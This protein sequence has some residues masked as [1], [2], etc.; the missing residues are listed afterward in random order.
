MRFAGGDDPIQRLRLAGGSAQGFLR[1]GR[2]KRQ[3]VLAF[4]NVGERFDACAATQ[5]AH[6]HSKSTIDLPGKND[7]RSRNS[8]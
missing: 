1:G 7:A 5:F 4:G 6:W 3:L 8:R 2:S